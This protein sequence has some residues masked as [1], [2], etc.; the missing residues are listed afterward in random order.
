MP[1][2][3]SADWVAVLFLSLT[4]CSCWV[5]EAELFENHKINLFSEVVV[6]EAHSVLLK[7]SVC[8]LHQI[9]YLCFSNSSAPYERI[10]HVL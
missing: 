4:S 9:I 2:I 10:Y 3:Y 6:D 1:N 5:W 7:L 8:S